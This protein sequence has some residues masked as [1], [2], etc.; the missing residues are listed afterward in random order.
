MARW[1]SNRLMC[2]SSEYFVLAK[3]T[4]LVWESETVQSEENMTVNGHFNLLLTN[5]SL[6]ISLISMK[7]WNWDD[8]KKIWDIWKKMKQ[9]VKSWKSMKSGVKYE[10]WWNKDFILHFIRIGQLQSNLKSNRTEKRCQLSLRNGFSR[11]RVTF[12]FFEH[13]LSLSLASFIR[14]TMMDK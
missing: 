14:L 2:R 11:I 5:I 4:I 13:L 1:R 10:I 9:H 12:F 7:S 3:A 6:P 8:F